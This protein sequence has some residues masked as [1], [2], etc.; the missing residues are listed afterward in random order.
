M[1]VYKDDNDASS[2]HNRMLDYNIKSFVSMATEI[3]PFTSHLGKVFS[4]DRSAR[5]RTVTCR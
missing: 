1:Q 5:S 3:K 2:L 4:K